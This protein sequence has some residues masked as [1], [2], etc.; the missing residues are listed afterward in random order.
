MARPIAGASSM[1]FLPAPV[2]RYALSHPGALPSI[3]SQS[4]VTGRRQ[5]VWSMSSASAKEG[6]SR[7]APADSFRRAH[8]LG[9]MSQPLLCS[10]APTH[11][12]PPALA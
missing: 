11:A 10:V 9:L 2:A 1:P 6:I 5:A 4:G 8:S 7:A 3:G 12:R